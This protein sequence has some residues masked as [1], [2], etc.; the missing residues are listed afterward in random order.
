MPTAWVMSTRQVP[1]EAGNE[2]LFAVAVISHGKNGIGAYL[3]NGTNGRVR[4]S[5]CG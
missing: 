5:W 3:A 1:P 2:E 4:H